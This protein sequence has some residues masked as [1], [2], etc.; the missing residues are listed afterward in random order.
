MTGHLKN[1]VALPSLEESLD[2]MAS[3]NV[4]ALSRP[5]TAWVQNASR[6]LRR[7]FRQRL[8]LFCGHRI[9]RTS[10]E[11]FTG[12]SIAPLPVAS[13]GLGPIA[14]IAHAI[15]GQGR[16]RY[17]L[18]DCLAKNPAHSLSGVSHNAYS[19]GALAS[20]INPRLTGKPGRFA[21]GEVPASAH[22][23]SPSL[24]HRDRQSGRLARAKVPQCPLKQTALRRGKMFTPRSLRSLLLPSKPTRASLNC[25]GANR[26]G[27][28]SRSGLRG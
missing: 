23:P 11:T 15:L 19:R 27:L 4:I 9:A 7:I 2:A 8:A 12:S 13:V 3:K 28:S 10:T 20:R 18:I 1:Q 6:T 26:P 22:S 14:A 25:L 16:C 21:L 5:S 24:R 17:P